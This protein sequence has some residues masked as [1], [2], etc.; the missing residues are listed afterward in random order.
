MSRRKRNSNAGFSLIEV[1]VAILVLTI[2]LVGTAALMSTTVSS[3]AKSHIMSTA[4]LL[5]SEKLE[6]LGRFDKLDTPVQAGGSLTANTVGY[7]DNVQI[8][9]DNG[10][11]NETT[12]TNGVSTSY[13]Q[14]PAAGMTVTPNAGL[15]PNSS[16]T[17][18]FNRRWLITANTPTAG[19]R[20][21]TVLVTAYSPLVAKVNAGTPP[22]ITFQMSTVR[23]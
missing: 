1:M 4:A 15:P 7:F 23:P 9:I 12:T 3:T 8:S 18:T 2:G 14:T 17:Q 11:I 13:V 16:D 6:D 10:Q 22:Q 19:V 5:A 20:T 21:V